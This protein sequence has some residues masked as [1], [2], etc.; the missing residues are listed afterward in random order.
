MPYNSIMNATII[1]FFLLLAAWFLLPLQTGRLLLGLE[2]W[3]NGV[4]SRVIR[5]DGAT[6]HYLE[7]GSGTTM[8]ALH[9]IAADAGHWTRLAGLL[10]KN[11]HIIA[12]D[13]P[14]FG[15]SEAPPDAAY[16]LDA[17]VDRLHR[18]INALEPGD[19]YLTGNSL[20]GQ[21]AAAY[22]ARYPEHVTGLCL[23][24]PGGII[25][26]RFSPVLK[27]VI[28]DEHNPFLVRNSAD[29]YR[30]LDACF[31]ARPWIP[32]PVRKLVLD[33][34]I[35]LEANT[36]A[37][38]DAIRF[39]SNSLETIAAKLS[40]PSLVLWGQNDEVLDVSGATILGQILS[41]STIIILERTGHLP[42]LERPA[43]CASHILDFV[44]SQDSAGK[45]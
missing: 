10:N 19:F 24:A 15:E 39:F 38:F 7:A 14:G 2:R 32:S 20:G 18:F 25:G 13:L 17:Q 42:M 44:R 3:R 33:R 29:F 34:T 41:G 21:L 43:L 4:H 22:A 11:L 35:R 40:T 27:A 30:L 31:H 12:P 45:G 8:F 6:W 36:L 28:R 16:T 5:L 9:G 37:V 1:L 23:L 26:A